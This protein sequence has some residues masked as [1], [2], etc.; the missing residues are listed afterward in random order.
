MMDASTSLSGTQIGATL[1]AVGGMQYLKNAKWFP[2]LKEGQKLI[3][4]LWSIAIA[5]FIAV[6]IHVTFTG[7][8]A[9]GWSFVG[10]TPSLWAM[11]V[12]LFRWAVQF[13]YQETGYSVLQGLQALAQLAATIQTSL[14]YKGEPVHSAV[15]VV[16]EVKV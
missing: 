14:N 9:E 7:S 15:A 2:L 6:G 1:L 10:S 5:G 8:A 16:P 3:N 13:V 12:G 4:R 11:I